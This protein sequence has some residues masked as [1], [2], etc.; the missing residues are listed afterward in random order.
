MGLDQRQS[1]ILEGV[2]ESYIKQA[3]PVGSEVL[4]E[5]RGLPFSSAT[6]RNELAQLEEK[7]YLFHPY[8]SS[9]R[10]PTD[11]G[12]R[13]F[14]D[15]IL[16][17]NGEYSNKEIKD[18]KEELFA[19]PEKLSDLLKVSHQIAKNLSRVCSS[20]IL[21]YAP[22][23]DILWKEGWEFV[24]K[25][26]EFENKEYWQQFLGAVTD[27]EKNIDKF[28]WIEGKVKVYIGKESPCSQNEMS[29][30]MTKSLIGKEMEEMIAILG[31]KRMDFKKNIGFLSKV[32][33]MLENL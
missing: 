12:W 9:G 26:P 27:F 15:K 2:C 20:L 4:K 25:E 14:V 30:V 10:I 1:E 23:R 8:V 5:K 21:T 3:L 7:H 28:D 32:S 31:P 17:E 29:V 18:I 16:E 24:F 6:I 19:K 11:K 22:E 13:F 33:E